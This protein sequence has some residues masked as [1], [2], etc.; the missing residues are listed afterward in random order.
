MPIIRR[1][2]MLNIDEFVNY[3]KDNISDYLPDK[4]R[5]A[6][7][8]ITNVN[9]NNGLVLRAI[10]II[11]KGSNIAPIIYLNDFYQEYEDRRALSSILREVAAIA[12]KNQHSKKCSSIA[13]DFVHFDYVKDKIV[14]QLINAQKNEELLRKIP[15]RTFADL[16]IIY[17][18]VI[19]NDYSG[20]ATITVHNEHMRYWNISENEIYALAIENSNFLLSSQIISMKDMILQMIPEDL[21]DLYAEEM[22]FDSIPQNMQMYIVTNKTDISGASAIIYSNELEKMAEKIG[23]D[24]YILPSTIH[25]VIAIS[26]NIGGK[27]EFESLV[28]EVNETQV[29]E[30]EQLSD[31]VYIYKK[32]TKEIKIA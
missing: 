32:E 31:S 25:E 6:E 19:S 13:N 1:K 15:H 11:E 3:V 18:V 29:N 23:T 16:A 7:I 5:D 12:E 9:E 26:T 21:R 20:A 27:E 30:N 28:K 4:L 24:L 14:M 17:N 10:L 8:Q 22:D 2:N